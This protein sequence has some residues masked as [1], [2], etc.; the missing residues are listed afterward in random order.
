MAQEAP[1][2]RPLKAELEAP[3]DPEEGL[4]LNEIHLTPAPA[5]DMAVEAHVSRRPEISEEELNKDIDLPRVTY[6]DARRLMT[7]TDF[8]E[9]L[10]HDNVSS[11][12]ARCGDADGQRRPAWGCEQCDAC[13]C[14]GH[15]NIG[16][17]PRQAHLG[18][19]THHAALKHSAHQ[20]LRGRADAE[21]VQIITI[22]VSRD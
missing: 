4:D 18:R 5:D 6:D 19:I 17:R 12:Q 13:R 11:V 8:F 20:T 15:V 7:R 3:A 21:P 14:R 9:G 22:D 1:R 10:D 16:P 2:L